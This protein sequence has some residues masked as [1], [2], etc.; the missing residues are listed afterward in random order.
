MGQV[1]GGVRMTPKEAFE[2]MQEIL[3]ITFDLTGFDEE[4]DVIRNALERAKKVEELLGLYRNLSMETDPFGRGKYWK[5]INKIEW[6]EL[7]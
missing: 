7:E 3:L 5:Q 4:L 6:E 1:K 2:K